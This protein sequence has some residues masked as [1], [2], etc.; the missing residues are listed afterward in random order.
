M[1]ST[2]SV[3]GKRNL[4]EKK[5]RNTY[6]T[7]FVSFNGFTFAVL[8]DWHKKLLQIIFIQVHNF[9]MDQHDPYINNKIPFRAKWRRK[10]HLQTVFIAIGYSC[11]SM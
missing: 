10:S 8:I 6:I 9:S 3:Q 1:K 11:L 4:V 7:D 5:L 2:K